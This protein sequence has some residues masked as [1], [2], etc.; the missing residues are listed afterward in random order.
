LGSYGRINGKVRPALGLSQSVGQDERFLSDFIMLID[1][2]T[3]EVVYLSYG[4][5]LNTNE[6]ENVRCIWKT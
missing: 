3:G 1:I 5:Q 2:E 4:K 6:Q